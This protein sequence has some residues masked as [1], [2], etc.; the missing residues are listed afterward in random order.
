MIT[1]L[2]LRGYTLPAPP[3]GKSGWQLLVTGVIVLG[4]LAAIAYVATRALDGRMPSVPTVA[5]AVVF[6]AIT[7]LG[8]TVGYHRLFTHRS[9]VARR[10]LKISLAVAGAMALQ[11][12]IIGW[13][14]AHRTRPATTCSVR[15]SGRRAPSASPPR[16]PSG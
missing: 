9:F 5:L 4:P 12:S 3:R 15:S 14:A 10:P 8:V 13:V 2:S 11:G 1:I 16:S 7:A 6:Y